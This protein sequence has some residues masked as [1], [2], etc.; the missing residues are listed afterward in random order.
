MQKNKDIAVQEYLIHNR[1]TFVSEFPFFW[2]N[3]LQSAK[4]TFWG[5]DEEISLDDLWNER[6]DFELLLSRKFH[7]MSEYYTYNLSDIK[8]HLSIEE[9]TATFTTYWECWQSFRRHETQYFYLKNKSTLI[10][11]FHDPHFVLNLLRKQ[12]NHELYDA[13]KG[14]LEARKEKKSQSFLTYAIIKNIS[15]NDM[16]MKKLSSHGMLLNVI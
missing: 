5:K 14:E 13:V 1:V 16:L 8:R 7:S 4:D 3:K 15:G 11:F 12:E 2:I 9:K 6:H 10:L